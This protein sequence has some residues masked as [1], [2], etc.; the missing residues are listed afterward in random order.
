MANEI[1]YIHLCGSRSFEE[2]PFRLQDALLLSQLCYNDMPAAATD[3]GELLR[4]IYP[5]TDLTK[6]VGS[7]KLLA[8][9]QEVFREMAVTERYGDLLVHHY[10]NVV[11]QE[12]V[13]QFS[14]QVYETPRY[15]CVAYRGTDN[16]LTGWK[17]DLYLSFQ[18]PVHAQNAAVYYLEQIAEVTDKPLLLCGHSKGGNLA[19]YAAAHVKPEIQ[20]RIRLVYS[21]DGPGLDENTKSSDGYKAVAGRIVSVIPEKSVVGLLMDYAE[22]YTVVK[23]S[24]ASLGQHDAY[25][26]QF[27]GEEL[28]LL[29]GVDSSSRVTDKALHA[30]LSKTS[31]EELKAFVGALFDILEATDAETIRGMQEQGWGA[32]AKMAQR[33]MSLDEASRKVLLDATGRLLGDTFKTAAGEAGE[34][35]AQNLSAVLEGVKKIDTAA[36]TENVLTP[37]AKLA[38]EASKGAVK[39]VGEASQGAGKLLKS[40]SNVLGELNE[41]KEELAPVMQ[42]IEPAADTILNAIPDTWKRTISGIRTKADGKKEPDAPKIIIPDEGEDKHA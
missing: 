3:R 35:L 8:E 7:L 40:M 29:E 37:A 33:T 18:S 41:K 4:N 24:A 10:V 20:R 26:W 30:F 31:P 21:F 28:V 1:D 17:E 6:Q 39:L 27:E 13:M 15:T 34:G 42:K 16:T 12:A 2:T 5:L 22:N 32:V 11:E 25:T 23:S 9:W 19:M 38:G 14:A 36:L